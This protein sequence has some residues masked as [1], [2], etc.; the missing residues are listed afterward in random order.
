MPAVH[1]VDANGTVR[2]QSPELDESMIEVVDRV[3]RITDLTTGA[4]VATYQLKPGEE[5]VTP[6]S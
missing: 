6:D 2:W 3:L 5:P 1:V 4:V